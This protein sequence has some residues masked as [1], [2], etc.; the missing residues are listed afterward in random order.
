MCVCQVIDEE[1][2]KKYWFGCHKWLAANLEDGLLERTLV[3][4]ST[5]PRGLM[6]E[7]KVCAWRV[8]TWD[9]G[10]PCPMFFE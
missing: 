10:H 7:Y 6:T 8:T 4:T 3:A 9:M 1:A 2:G 5:D